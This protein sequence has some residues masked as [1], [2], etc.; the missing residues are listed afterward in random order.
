MM[1]DL[2]TQLKQSYAARLNIEIQNLQTKVS[3]LFLSKIGVVKSM[4][5]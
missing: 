1:I 5:C 2:C 4:A 3:N